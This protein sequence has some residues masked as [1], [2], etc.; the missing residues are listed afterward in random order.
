M[1]LVGFWVVFTLLCWRIRVGEAEI[2]KQTLFDLLLIAFVGGLIG[3]RI[4]Y[5][6][7]YDAA[8]FFTNV[9]QIFSPFNLSDGSF[10]GLYGMSYHGAL[11]GSLLGIYFFAIFK[12]LNFLMLA[13]FIVPALPAGYFFGRIGNFMNGELFGRVT[14]SEFGMYFA[15]S[16]TTLRYPSQI[17]EAFGEGIFLFCLL[18]KIRNQKTFPQGSISWFYIFGYSGLRFVC[19]FFR[20]PDLQLGFVFW[21]LTM[22]QI[23]S[24]ISIFVLFF[25][26]FLKN[27]KSAIIKK[28]LMKVNLGCIRKSS[29]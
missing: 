15:N 26:L 5:V 19:E 21:G 1:F 17:F 29:F 18:W 10:Q 11:V 13:D 3:G 16:P 6:I 14:N 22:G 7:I 27:Q 25:L 24:L 8:Y 20:Q 28:Q 9:S 4:S 2:N 23:L 12:K